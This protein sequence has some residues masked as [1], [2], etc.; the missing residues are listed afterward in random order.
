MI[1]SKIIKT[2]GYRGYYLGQISEYYS[3]ILDRIIERINFLLKK[4][5]KILVIRLVIKYPAQL[6]AA[7]RN[8]C[9][10]YFMEEY[11]RKLSRRGFGPHYV[12]VR[13]QHYSGNQHYHL[14][15]L[16]DARAIQYFNKLTEANQLWQ[17]AIRKFNPQSKSI[18]L[19]LIHKDTAR[20]G[21]MKIRHGILV[22]KNNYHLRMACIRYCAYLA[23]CETKGRGPQ[24]CNDFNASQL[25]KEKDCEYEFES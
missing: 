21:Q 8:D 15:L 25:P 11:R 20:Y 4:C 1:R 10:Q 7:K 12:W 5:G 9:F 13:E 16:L 3:V 14:V 6:N 23:K 2:N 22:A 24:N 17:T 18:P 19:K